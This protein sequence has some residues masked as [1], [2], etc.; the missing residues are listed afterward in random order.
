[1]F[2]VV[3]HILCYYNVILPIL[4]SKLRWDDCISFFFLIF[5]G[6]RIVIRYRIYIY[7]RM[8]KKKI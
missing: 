1:M 6:K 8:E 5:I 2:G 7:K 4:N 3:W